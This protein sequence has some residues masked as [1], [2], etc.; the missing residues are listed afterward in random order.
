[1]ANEIEHAAFLVTIM[2]VVSGGRWNGLQ[3]P[4]QAGQLGRKL[5]ERSRQAGVDIGKLLDILA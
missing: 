1:L 2:P 5:L 4:P 3:G